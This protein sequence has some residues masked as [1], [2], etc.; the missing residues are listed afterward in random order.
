MPLVVL[1]SS[2]LL[3]AVFFHPAQS[4]APPAAQAPAAA[5]ATAPVAP[6]TTG[7]NPVKPTPESQAR[8]KKIW[9]YDC[10]MCHGDKGDGKGDVGVEMKLTLKDY[11]NPDS[12]KDMTDG[13]LFDVIKNGKGQMPG[14][15][16]RAKP[17]EVWNLVIMI[18]N[19]SK[20]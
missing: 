2:T 3:L 6:A 5:P 13:Q 8:A 16:G 11:T 20:K 10:S 4:Q 9:G 1:L 12:L 18:R 15:A 19:M 7:P 17:D 14:E